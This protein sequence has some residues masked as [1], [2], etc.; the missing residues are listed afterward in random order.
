MEEPMIVTLSGRISERVKRVAALQHQDVV[1]VIEAALE[2]ALPWGDDDFAEIEQRESD[3]AATPE[4]QAYIA[5]HPILKEKYFG[6]YA[7]VYQGE[8]IDMD[9]DF[10]ALYDRIDMRYPDEFVWMSKV[11]EEPIPTLFFRSPRFIRNEQA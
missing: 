10:D 4:M 2:D 1:E 8:L 5:L 6:K 3:E 11:E 7:A 9:D